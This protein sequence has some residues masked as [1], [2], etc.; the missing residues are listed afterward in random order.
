MTRTY[1]Q[2]QKMIEPC[3][4]VMILFLVRIMVSYEYNMVNNCMFDSN[5]ML[6][7]YVAEIVRSENHLL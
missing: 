2:Y 4:V 5:I 7:F 3:L 1:V 6:I